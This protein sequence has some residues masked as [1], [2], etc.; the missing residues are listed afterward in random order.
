MPH[1]NQESILVAEMV[2]TPPCSSLKK[3]RRPSAPPSLGDVPF[4]RFLPFSTV[5]RSNQGYQGGA[6]GRLFFSKSCMEAQNGKKRT[7]GILAR[8]GGAPGRLFFFKE[9]HG[10]AKR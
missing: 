8:E 10:G 1:K 6:P 4:A 9:L 3:E 7:N 5:I 2:F